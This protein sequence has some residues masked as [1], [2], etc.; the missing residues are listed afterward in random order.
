MHLDDLCGPGAPKLKLACPYNIQFAVPGV[1]N[2]EWVGVLS[3]CAPPAHATK[4]MTASQAYAEIQALTQLKGL[5]DP[6]MYSSI[7]MLD[8]VMPGDTVFVSNRVIY[9]IHEEIVKVEIQLGLGRGIGTRDIRTWFSTVGSLMS[10]NL[11]AVDII[12]RFHPAYAPSWVVGMPPAAPP[13]PTPPPPNVFRLSINPAPTPP[14]PSLLNVTESA[15]LKWQQ[16]RAITPDS[17]D[18]PH[19]CLRCGSPAYIGFSST[20]CS[21]GLCNDTNQ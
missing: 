12:N 13:A 2:F 6:N 4:H 16:D 10:I 15:R 20:D 8:D 3:P 18:Y 17:K 5:A 9:L 7:W 19:T 11:S 1:V 14:T 21:N